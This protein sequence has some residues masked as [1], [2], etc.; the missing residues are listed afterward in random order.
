MQNKIKPEF[1]GFGAEVRRLRKAAGLNQQQLAAAVNVTRSYITQIES[2]RTRCRRD[3]ALRLDRALRS[4]ATIVESWDELLDSIK[5]DKYPKFFANFPRAEQVAIML[6]AYEDRVVYGLFQTE[7]YA[8]ILLGDDDAVKNRMQRKEVLGRVPAP[9]VTVVM[10]ETVLY[11]E[12]GG[13]AVMKEQLEYLLAL[14]DENNVN[15]QILPIS[16]VRNVWATFAIATLAD[17]SQVVYTAKAYGGE[18]S[19]DPADL[20]FVNESMVRLQAEA[21]NTR[22]SRA[23][24]RRVIEERWNQEG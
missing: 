4:G 2:G 15:L 3:F 8:R 22:D 17:Q 20:A 24:I 10:D 16:Y 1:L 6:R 14:S 19:T 9:A 18:T 23:L 12:V 13:A 11:R 21:L 5:S 7:A